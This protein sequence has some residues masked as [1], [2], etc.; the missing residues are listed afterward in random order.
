MGR[1]LSHFYGMHLWFQG[2][3]EVIYVLCA[4]VLLSGYTHFQVASL[5]FLRAGEDG[6]VTC[7]DTGAG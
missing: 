6:E 5:G 4:N 2:I 1:G 3:D 7:A